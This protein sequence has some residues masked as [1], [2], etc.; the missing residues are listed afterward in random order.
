VVMYSKKYAGNH[1][2]KGNVPNNLK[3][4]VDNEPKTHIIKKQYV[5][6][7]DQKLNL[8]QVSMGAV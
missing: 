4:R 7:D 5:Q 3:R 6:F 1:T 2:K 8:R